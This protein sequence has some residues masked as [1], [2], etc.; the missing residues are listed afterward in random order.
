MSTRRK[1]PKGYE[2]PNHP[3]QGEARIAEESDLL[4][5][6]TVTKN[7]G[8][9]VA[10]SSCVAC[11]ARRR[12]LGEAQGDV[13]VAQE[14]GAEFV[15]RLRR[16]GILGD[17]DDIS[18]V[19][20]L[21]V[22]DLLLDAVSRRSPTDR[23]RVLDSS[24]PTV[25]RSRPHHRRQRPRHAPVGEGRRGRRRRTAFG[26]NNSPPDDLHPERAESQE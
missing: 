11:A 19:L 1:T 16:I 26:E 6:G 15:A 24:R 17:N 9:S 8:S 12:L 3:Y 7:K 20:S 21:D 14:A 2:A 18:A 23:V 13:D 10:Q 5:P 4:S 22:T 25:H